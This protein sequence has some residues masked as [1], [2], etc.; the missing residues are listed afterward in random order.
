MRVDKPAVVVNVKRVSG[1]KIYLLKCIINQQR[2]HQQHHTSK[3]MVGVDSVVETYRQPTNADV[4]CHKNYL[5]LAHRL[6]L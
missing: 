5:A 6:L 1:I 3:T 2:Q 4:M